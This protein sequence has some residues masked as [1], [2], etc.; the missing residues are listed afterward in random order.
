M[1]NCEHDYQNFV[2][3]GRARLHCP[4]CDEDIT[5]ELI[6]INQALND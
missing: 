4:K 5:L 2:K 6:Y 1:K 3:K